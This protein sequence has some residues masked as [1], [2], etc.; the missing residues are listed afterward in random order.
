[1]SLRTNLS[2]LI[3]SLL[4]LLANGC[5]EHNPSHHG[6]R[7]TPVVAEIPEAKD[8]KCPRFVDSNG[9]GKCDMAESG[10]CDCAKNGGSCDCAKNGG[11][12]DCAK[13]GGTCGCGKAAESKCPGA[14]KA[15]P[16]P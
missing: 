14:A 9:D 7:A 11:T 4:A 8:T 1:M 16:A 10:T 2:V 15:K 13:N 12:C 3:M 6:E 5:A